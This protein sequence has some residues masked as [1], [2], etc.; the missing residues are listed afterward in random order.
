VEI[1][2]IMNISPKAVES[3]VQ[4]AKTGVLKKMNLNE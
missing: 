3:L 1:A 4:R 2:A